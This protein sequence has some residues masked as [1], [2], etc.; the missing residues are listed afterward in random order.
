[1]KITDEEQQ[2]VRSLCKR[3]TNERKKKTERQTQKL[4]T[5]DNKRYDTYANGK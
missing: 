3:K 5:K 1:M 4:L 2:K